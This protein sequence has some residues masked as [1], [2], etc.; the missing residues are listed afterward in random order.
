MLKEGRQVDDILKKLM[1]YFDSWRYIKEVDD[2]IMQV[3]DIEP[4]S[5]IPPPK[6][7]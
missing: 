3:D 7:I 4:L 1:I 6:S 2:K 5:I